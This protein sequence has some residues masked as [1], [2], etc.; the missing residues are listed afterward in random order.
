MSKSNSFSEIVGGIFGFTGFL[1]IMSSLFTVI[2]QAY[3]FLRFGYW[4]PLSL[5]DGINIAYKWAYGE[6]LLVIFSEWSGAQKILEW[7]PLS[8][9]LF[10]GGVLTEFA[11]AFVMLAIDD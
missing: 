8:A 1:V 11:G 6:N 3:Y 10:L 4:L 7:L 9:G 2:F 5:N